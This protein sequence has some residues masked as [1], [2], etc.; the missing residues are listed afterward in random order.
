MA[1]GSFW[2][3]AR[4]TK[5]V[6]HWITVIYTN[7]DYHK[8][9]CM[10]ASSEINSPCHQRSLTTL[11]MIS[12]AIHIVFLNQLTWFSDYVIAF[13]MMNIKTDRCTGVLL[14]HN[15]TIIWTWVQRTVSWLI[16]GNAL[17]EWILNTGKCE[18]FNPLTLIIFH[19]KMKG[20]S[21]PCS[22]A[23]LAI[24]LVSLLSCGPMNRDGTYDIT[25]IDHTALN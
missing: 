1:V 9:R 22:R 5:D 13:C 19:Y 21:P 16:T 18:L 14:T 10:T 20:T 15:L 2:W 23:Y 4:T 7:T 3:D 17:S 6:S 24:D 11:L 8:P 12:D 25:I